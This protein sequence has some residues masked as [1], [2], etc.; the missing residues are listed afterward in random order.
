MKAK[1]LRPTMQITSVN[2][3]QQEK[4]RRRKSVRPR[5]PLAKKQKRRVPD[6]QVSETPPE[7]L[8]P[9]RPTPFE[10]DPDTAAVIDE[11]ADRCNELEDE[12]QRRMRD[13]QYTPY[14]QL[15]LAEKRAERRRYLKANGRLMP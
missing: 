4:R 3:E 8:F 14:E 12:Y 7:D 10:V 6:G 13:Y 2:G 1:T 5:G 11:F 15:S 9:C